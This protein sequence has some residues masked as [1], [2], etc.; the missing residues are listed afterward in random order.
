V[1]GVKTTIPKICCPK[2][3]GSGHVDLYPD[4][5]ETL[6]LV[7]TLKLPTA[8][9]IKPRLTNQQMSVTAVNNRLE[10]LRK[11]GLVDRTRQGRQWVYKPTTKK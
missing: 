8:S 5:L 10:D 9:A 4:L 3:N 1:S 2:C 7:R 11:L 6:K